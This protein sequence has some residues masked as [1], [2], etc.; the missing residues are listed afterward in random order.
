MLQ[1]AGVTHRAM[2]AFVDEAAVKTTM[3]GD[4]AEPGE[5]AQALA[6]RKA[7]AISEVKPR[8]LVI[9]ADQVLVCAGAMFDKPGDR[10]RAR[11]QLQALRGRDHQLLSAASLAIGS[12]I[13]WRHLDTAQLT[14]RRF[15]DGFLERYLAAID[16]DVLACAGSYQVEGRGAQLFSRI[17]GDF[18]AIIGL[19]LLPILEI[20]RS[21]GAMPS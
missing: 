8:A 17:D 15:S 5:I 6:D 2:A 3:T 21:H 12:R 4:G 9:G 11:A 18:Y 19:P 1:A 10:E 7:L 13:V 16:D 14:M 20:L